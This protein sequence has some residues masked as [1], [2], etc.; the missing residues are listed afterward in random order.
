VKRL[1]L[2]AIRAYWLLWPSR[3]RRTCLFRES[4]SRYVYRITNEL[5]IVRGAKAFVQRYRSCRHGYAF[6]TQEHTL[7]ILLADGTFLGETDVAEHLMQELHHTIGRLERL[8]I[9]VLHQSRI[10]ECSQPTVA[11]V[12]DPHSAIT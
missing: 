11:A 10:N 8:P 5:G 2:L 1:V 4:C 3:L 12:F 9:T 7:G 6:T